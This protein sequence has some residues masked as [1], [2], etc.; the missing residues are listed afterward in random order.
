MWWG[1][2]GFIFMI[3]MIFLVFRLVSGRS[4]MCGFGQRDEV[5][6][7]HARC[8]DV[9]LALKARIDYR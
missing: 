3:L 6:D 7:R 1:Y 4:G 8:E 9:R 2:V 5:D